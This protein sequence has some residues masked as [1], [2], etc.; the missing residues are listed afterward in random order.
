MRGQY[1]GWLLAVVIVLARPDVSAA[2]TAPEIV[3]KIRQQMTCGEKCM[4]IVLFHVEGYGTPKDFI[5]HRLIQ[6]ERHSVRADVVSHGEDHGKVYLSIFDVGSQ[7]MPDQWIYIPEARKPRRSLRS[8]RDDIL[9]TLV[10]FFFLDLWAWLS[11][12]HYEWAVA[13]GTVLEGSPKLA[14]LPKIKLVWEKSEDEY[15]ITDLTLYQGSVLNRTFSFRNYWS[16]PRGH[17][18]P[19]EVTVRTPYDEESVITAY[20]WYFVS[21]QPAEVSKMFYAEGMRR[22][23]DDIPDTYILAHVFSR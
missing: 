7:K 23:W 22:I 15:R 20:V 17:S 3:E 4:E 12:V 11:P 13:G 21:V 10:N 1:S 19:A 8:P 5:L 18:R 14:S 2:L 6:G 9:D 16:V